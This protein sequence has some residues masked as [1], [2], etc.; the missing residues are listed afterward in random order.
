[1]SIDSKELILFAFLNIYHIYQ[2]NVGGF[3]TFTKHLPQKPDSFVKLYVGVRLLAGTHQTVEHVC[4]PTVFI[5]IGA[6]LGPEHGR[7]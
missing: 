3:P 4:A 6:S 5:I 7:G 1:M 2:G